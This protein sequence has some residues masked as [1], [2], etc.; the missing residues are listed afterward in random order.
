MLSCGWN[1]V[2]VYDC[3]GDDVVQL[4]VA[5][6]ENDAKEAFRSM[7]G[8]YPWKCSCYL[9]D[10]LCVTKAAMAQSVPGVRLEASPARGG[11][12]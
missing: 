3:H 2:S 9:T 4:I 11:R 8:K 6:S 10:A 1:I 7:H 5:V 12:P